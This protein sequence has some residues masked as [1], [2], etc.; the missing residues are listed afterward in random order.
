M[1]TPNHQEHSLN[2]FPTDTCSVEPFKI[3]LFLG[4]CRGFYYLPASCVFLGMIRLRVIPV[5]QRSVFIA[6]RRLQQ[7]RNGVDSAMASHLAEK[8]RRLQEAGEGLARGMLRATATRKKCTVNH[9][10][11]SANQTYFHLFC[12]HLTFIINLR[13]VKHW[14]LSLSWPL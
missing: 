6:L 13:T 14:D 1:Q 3:A 8:E 4:N 9:K 11:T 2:S 7:R 10:E 5:N 12:Q